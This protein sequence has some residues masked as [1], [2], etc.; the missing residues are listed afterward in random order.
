MHAYQ[1]TGT[2]AAKKDPLRPLKIWESATASSA[3]G[4]GIG[5]GDE[6]QRKDAVV[7]A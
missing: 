2:Q 3:I 1:R 6:E 4:R 5:N 7:V